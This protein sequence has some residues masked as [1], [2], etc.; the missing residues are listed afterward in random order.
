MDERRTQ[1]VEVARAIDVPEKG[2]LRVQVGS[3]EIG[4]FRADDGFFAIENACPHAGVPL[5]Q[6]DLKGCIV[7][8]LAH[9]FQY[10]L[11]TGYAADGADGFP[12]PRF[13]VR[14]RGESLFIEAECDE[15]GQLG[16]RPLRRLAPP[17]ASG[18]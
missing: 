17:P 14:L 6:G 7:T 13:A 12:I 15:D 2:G 16:P 4:L 1:L 11:R 9:G 3:V 8:C 18:N 10:D 5:S